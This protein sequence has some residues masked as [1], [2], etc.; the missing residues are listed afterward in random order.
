MTQKIYQVD[1]FAQ[2]V[3]SG[4]PAAVCPLEKW[5]SEELLQKIAMENN[6]AETAFYVRQGDEF[7]IRWF[8]PTVEVDLCGHATLAAAHVL[9]NYENF[10][11]ELIQFYSHRSGPLTVTRKADLLTLNF[12]T[13]V[14]EEL[15]LTDDLTQCFPVKAKQAFKGKTD[16]LLV[17]NSESEIRTLVPDLEKIAKLKGRGIIVTAK[18]DEVD[19]VSRF[20]APQS[21]INEDPVTGSAHT[22]LT[23]YWAKQLGKNELSAIQLSERKGYLTCK[24]LNDRVE[25]SGQAK[26]YLKGQIF[27]E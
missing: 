22:T 25:I 23:P 24:Y 15:P 20:F 17:L 21:G 3:F 12:P 16:Y 5:L 26:L 4:N 9:F 10:Q 11:G 14:Y 27:I 1:A 2:S 19:F 6:L 8:T 13:D 18:G 7:H